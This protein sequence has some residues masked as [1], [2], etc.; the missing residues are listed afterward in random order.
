MNPR[1]LLT[2]FTAL[3]VLALLAPLPS[4]ASDG[5][6][7]QLAQLVGASG[8][9]QT[10]TQGLYGDLFPDG[11][12]A[13]ADAEVL[14]LDLM[15]GDSA[16]RLLV[17]TTGSPWKE[18]SATLL[19]DAG[20][21]KTY[22]LWS[23]PFNGIHPMLYLTS[24]DGSEWG[25]VLE[26][27]GTIFAPKLDLQLVVTRDSHRR[28]ESESTERTVIH[29][30][31]SE[32]RA[33]GVEKNYTALI[34][35]NGSYVGRNAS[36]EL[37]SLVEA[38]LGAELVG[39]AANALVMQPGGA[40]G[41]LTAAFTLQD[42][43]ELLSLHIEVLPMALSVLAAE[44]EAAAAS[45]DPN[46]DKTLQQVVEQ[47]LAEHGGAFHDFLLTL[48]AEDVRL[49][50]ESWDQEGGDEGGLQILTQKFGPRII[51]I[52]LRVGSN[53]LQ[54]PAAEGILTI[55]PYAAD[56]PATPRHDLKIYALGRWPLP[57]DI[58]DGV[59]FLISRDGGDALAA[60]PQST[61]V[62]DDQGA[63]IGVQE[64]VVFRETLDD[65]SWSESRRLMLGEDLSMDSALEAL[66]EHVRDR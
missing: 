49:L 29:V 28:G 5:K 45:W 56:Q 55:A 35:E 17:P 20:A 9:L 4:L 36:L 2:I 62:V 61:E 14:A 53:G 8:D 66:A 7:A 54:N 59:R 16:Q 30:G 33:S 48:I 40:E 60:W 63:V 58:G 19:F 26:I 15:H 43:S 23:A 57:E 41:S 22:L 51:H 11:T 38:G 21:S 27:V 31:W 10:L 39:G 6:G 65:G 46:G 44:V 37:G 13:P 47:T 18:E 24:F 52:G 64:E 3:A 25:E 1:R 42:S 50:I 12:E 32:P 34:L